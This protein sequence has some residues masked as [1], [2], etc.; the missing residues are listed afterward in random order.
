MIFQFGIIF[1]SRIPCK[2]IIS[3]FWILECYNTYFDKVALKKQEEPS[4]EVSAL[5]W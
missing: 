3:I 2:E 1:E 4:Q 5:Q